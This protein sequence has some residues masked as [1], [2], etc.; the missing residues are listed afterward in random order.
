MRLSILACVFMATSQLLIAAPVTSTGNFEVGVDLHVD[1]GVP[2]EWDFPLVTLDGITNYTNEVLGNEANQVDFAWDLW[3]NPD[4]FIF[5]QF[6]LRN[7]SS[8]DRTFSINALLPIIGP[9]SS[10]LYGGSIF[11]EANDSNA[12]GSLNFSTVAGTP[13]YSAT[14]DGAEVLT[15]LDFTQTTICGG[16][17][18]SV[19]GPGVFDGLPGVVM[20]GDSLPVGASLVG[21]AVQNTIGID[22]LF[23][24]SAGD[25]VTI[26]TYFEVTPVP[27]PA[28][29]LLLSSG[30]ALLFSSLS[31]RR[32]RQ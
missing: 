10:S 12:D 9:G 1:N 18:C 25:S 16:P 3:V 8:E 6:T 30:M 28:A 14:I 32:N 31:Y 27:V 26:D 24:L 22:L 13:V 15:L 19:S 11:V 17:G 21:P 29:L 7:L 2:L 20:A 23:S 4:P 5:S